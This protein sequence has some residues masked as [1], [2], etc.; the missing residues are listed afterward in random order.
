MD[1]PI[2]IYHGKC[3]D[4]FGAAYAF[5]KKHG[6]NMEYVARCHYDEIPDLK[7]REVFMADIAFEREP[8]L[9]IKSEAKSLLVLDHHAS[10]ME[11]LQDLEFCHFDM[12]HSGAILAWNNQFPDEE[13][14][15]LL[16]YIEDRD[17]W[18]W[19]LPYAEEILF[20]LDSYKYNFQTWRIL[21][22]RLED[23]A[24]FEELKRE[25]EAIR[26]YA[27]ALIKRLERDSYIAEIK[28]YNVRVINTPFFRSEIVNNLAVGE[29]FAAGY[30]FDGESFAFSLRSTGPDAVDVSK[31]AAMFSGGGGHKSAA[32][33]SVKDLSELSS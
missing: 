7:D 9:K 4:G 26:R 25:G 6:D 14:P 8:M 19:Q 32:G 2:L 31:I 30:H 3:P 17:L 5:W 18:K 22:K 24:G 11:E 12:S 13:S 20:A 28:G 16:Q 27:N 15:L 23:T 21:E 1:K 29:P 10:A 33:F